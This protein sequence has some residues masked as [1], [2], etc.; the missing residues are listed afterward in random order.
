MLARHFSKFL[1]GKLFRCSDDPFR[2]G[3]ADWM[4]QRLTPERKQRRISGPIPR[5]TSEEGDFIVYLKILED[6]HAL[7]DRK[8]TI[9]TVAKIAR[10]K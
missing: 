3:S 1:L 7:P 6:A 9:Y 2:Q 10:S 8:R 5:G 4:N